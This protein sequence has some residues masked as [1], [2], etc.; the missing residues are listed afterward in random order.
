MLYSPLLTLISLFNLLAILC[1][2]R[3]CYALLM[4]LN[5][6]IMTK[7]ALGS[8]VRILSGQKFLSVFILL[9]ITVVASHTGQIGVCA[10]G[11]K[12]KMKRKIRAHIIIRTISVCCA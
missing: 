7:L 4:C 10:L 5:S 3:L 12:Q 6:R 8:Y 2:T 11:A 1:Y 9:P